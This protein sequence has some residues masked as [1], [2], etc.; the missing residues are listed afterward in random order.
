MKD[1]KKAGLLVHGC[2]MLG[3]KGETKETARKTI[4]F[5]KEID[6]DTA[7]FFPIMVYPGTEAFEWAKAHHHLRSLNWR[8]WLTET[9]SHNCM[10]STPDLKAKELVEWCD[11]GRMEF[12]LRPKYLTAKARQALFDPREIPRLAKSSRTFFKYLFKGSQ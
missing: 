11:Q 4:D 3:N 10:V 8:D 5:A 2:F 12:Y 6:P 9:G 1:S 7:Q